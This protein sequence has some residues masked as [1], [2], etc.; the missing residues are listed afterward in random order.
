M[1]GCRTPAGRVRRNRL[2]P[3]GI[4][5]PFTIAEV[6]GDSAEQ[7]LLA[8]GDIRAF[9]SPHRLSRQSS[10]VSHQ[11]ETVDG[12]L[13]ITKWWARG[14]EHVTRKLAAIVATDIVGYSRLIE[15]DEEGTLACQEEGTLACQK[16]HREKFIDPKIAEQ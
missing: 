12:A 1:K 4:R 16:A 3:A 5:Q 10:L 11:R 2:Y 15:L 8:K 13:R 9:P 7:L 6:R 14:E